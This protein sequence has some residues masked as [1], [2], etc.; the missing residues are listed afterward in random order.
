VAQIGAVIGRN[1]SYPPLRAVAAIE[2]APLQAAL[3]KLADADILLLQGLP[4]RP[5]IGSS[6]R[7][8]RTRLMKIC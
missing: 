8:F 2:E 6:I 4:P 5:I 7:S 1:F 3:E